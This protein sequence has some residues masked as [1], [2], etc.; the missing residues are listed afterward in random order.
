[1]LGDLIRRERERRGLS[2]REAARR[3]G[4]SAAYL[5]ELEHDRNPTTGRAPLPSPV[6]LA[7]IERAL[8]IGMATLL[9]LA[10]AA[11]PRSRHTLLVLAG[12]SAP[13]DAAAASGA[14]EASWIAIGTDGSPAAALGATATAVAGRSTPFGL[15]FAT[16]S[17][18]LRRDAAAVVAAERTWEADVSAACEAAAGAAPVANVCVYRA[19]DL[20]TV[21][22]ADPLDVALGL[23]RAHPRVA[24][25]GPRGRVTTG[26][27]AIE[28]IL[29]LVRPAAV[30]PETW[31][32]L[33]AAAAAGLHRETAAA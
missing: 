30:A 2:M 31:A 27:A 17:A 29:G 19:G 22:G 6:V 9:D 33:S 15:V 11:P 14:S 16:G 5:V 1:M 23:V 8:G 25:Q 21:A 3:I 13:P 24:V 18:R 28:V 10:G 20:R 7:G 4:I 12:G 32:S 26:P